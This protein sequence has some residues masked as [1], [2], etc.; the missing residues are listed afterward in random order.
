MSSHG[1]I[2]L[3]DEGTFPRLGSG[4][5]YNVY[6]VG[7]GRVLKVP[8]SH[9]GRVQL[10]FAIHRDDPTY[11]PEQ[12][13]A[14]AEAVDGVTWRS[15]RLLEEVL[16]YLDGRLLGNP[17]LLG[18][19]IYEQD[20]LRMIID[21]LRHHPFKEGA[22]IID[23]YIETTLALWQRGIS[24]VVFNFAINS[25]IDGDGK[26]ALC[27]LGELTTSKSW[28]RRTVAGQEWLRRWSYRA[29]PNDE[30]RAYVRRTLGE[31]LTPSRVEATWGT[32][33]WDS[34]R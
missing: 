2:H 16:P 3:S 1:I 33:R 11:L 14:W 30:L 21:F 19:A 20:K 26:V 34:K 4:W 17:T 28:V 24:D 27:D 8:I 31:E 18:H 5:Q 10:A 29:L 13:A 23:R 32:L 12:A 25:G 9:E 15:Y 7:D 6:D 22:A